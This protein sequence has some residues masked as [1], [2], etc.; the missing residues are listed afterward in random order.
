M[1]KVW[2]SVGLLS[3]CFFGLLALPFCF[4]QTFEMLYQQYNQN[5]HFW[6]FLTIPSSSWTIFW[7]SLVGLGGWLISI[8]SIILLS[9]T[10][11]FGLI[12]R[13]VFPFSFIGDVLM[14]E[15]PY[16][17]SA[18]GLHFAAVIVECFSWMK[19]LPAQSLDWSMKFFNAGLGEDTY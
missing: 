3:L 12:R 19:F 2:R 8:P 10:L 15:L 17:A 16:N 9:F 11:H 13:T 4:Q 14:I 5:F 1:Q 6:S 18:A 7:I